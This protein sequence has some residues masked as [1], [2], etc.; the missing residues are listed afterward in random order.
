MDIE[1]LKQILIDHKEWLNGDGG[2]RANLKDAILIGIDLSG[3]DLGGANL[4]GANLRDANL[5]DADLSYAHLGGANLS[6]ANLKGVSLIGADLRYANL[7][8]VNLWG[9]N[10]RDADLTNANLWRA[11][12]LNAN[13]ENARL[14]DADFRHAY[15]TNTKLS[16]MNLREADLRNAHLTDVDLRDVKYSDTILN[17]QCP[18]EGSFIAFK[19]L[20]D[21]RICKLQILEDS[22]RSSAT[23][24]KCRCDKAKVLDIYSLDKKEHYEDGYS[25]YDKGFKYR[26]GEIIFVDDFDEDR[27]EECSTGI[28]F[29]ITEREA[30]EYF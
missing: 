14:V 30:I 28:H 12:L 10:L 4:R 24:R 6:G 9:A 11:D 26:V 18:E 29:F 23:T 3:A 21:D 5:R 25:K 17:M 19:K 22:K 20:R 1:K 27:W 15:L 7:N 2:Q 16:R 13:L 8:G